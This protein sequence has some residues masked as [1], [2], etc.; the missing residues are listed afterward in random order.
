[1]FEEETEASV[2]ASRGQ[3][4][5]VDSA[6][7]RAEGCHLAGGS[8][9]VGEGWTEEALGKGCTRDIKLASCCSSSVSPKNSPF[10]E[11]E[12]EDADVSCQAGRWMGVTSLRHPPGPIT[13]PDCSGH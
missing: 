2:S 12:D 5:E 6:V 13:A 8:R 7:T 11:D 1:M 3:G 4:Q 10:F 9:C